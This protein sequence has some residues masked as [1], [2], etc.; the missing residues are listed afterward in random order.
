[1]ISAAEM[2]STRRGTEEK[3]ILTREMADGSAYRS[4]WSLSLLLFIY[5]FLRARLLS[6]N[7]FPF[8]DSLFL[9]R[10]NFLLSST[11]LQRI[12]RLTGYRQMYEYHVC[13]RVVRECVGA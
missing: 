4:F 1:M 12:P 10:R 11:E 9:N 13:V 6:Y 8:Q 5:F 2:L 7:P 3:P